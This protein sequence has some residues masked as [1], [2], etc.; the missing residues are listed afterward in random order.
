MATAIKINKEQIL[1]FLRK[2]P[3]SI[4][5]GVVCVLLGVFQFFRSDARPAAEVELEAKTAEA[6]RLALNIKNAAQLSEHH[7]LVAASIR[8]ID[9]RLIHVSA[10]ATNLQY[11]YKIEAETG[12]KLI[13]LRQNSISANKEKKTGNYLAVPYTLSVQGDYAKLILFL[14]HLENGNY[15]CRVNSALLSSSRLAAT[16]KNEEA[17]DGRLVITLNLELVG[18]P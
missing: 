9:A 4:G 12:T 18:V 14:Q 2:H 16:E 5:C 1:N 17:S 11:F 6:E 10:L 3:V 8:K 7:D 15:F 13:D